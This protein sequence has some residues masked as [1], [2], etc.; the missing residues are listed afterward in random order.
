MSEMIHATPI[1]AFAILVGFMYIGDIVSCKTKAIIPAMLLFVIFLMIGA[2]NGLIPKDIISVPGFTSSYASYVILMFLVDMGSSISLKQFAQQWKTVVVGVAAIAG[3]A[4][5]VLTAGTAIYGW[6]YA[7]VAAPPIS[8]GLVATMTMS[9]KALAMGKDNLASL[10]VLVFTVQSFPAYL[11]L[12]FFLKKHGRQLLKNRSRQTESLPFGNSNLESAKKLRLVD[13][14]PETYK[15]S[16]YYLF[17][18][19]ILAL[20]ANFTA[21]LIGNL[22]APTVFGL[23]YGVLAANF[24][25][26]EK[27][28]MKKSSSS[29]F[30]MFSSLI[31]IF[32]SLAASDPKQIAAMIVPLIIL[33]AIGILGI[34]IGSCVVGKLLGYSAALSFSIGLNCLLGFPLN[35]MLTTEAIKVTAQN[36]EEAAYLTEHLLPHM[37][38]AGFVCVT[39]GSTIFASII[40]NFM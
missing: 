39:I 34:F 14:I 3:I 19:A 9:G 5:L 27:D 12:P 25:I 15:T 6:D 16:A 33:I 37:L 29:G 13:K 36:E 23:L 4:L 26:I 11:A 18:L 20:L 10:A 7:A 1:L 38:I 8:G 2:W 21:A 40:E 22:I 17:C 32:A 31:T 35:Y 24:G 28:S 30:L